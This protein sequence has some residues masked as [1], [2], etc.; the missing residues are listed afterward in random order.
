M[1][2]RHGLLLLVFVASA[3]V[4]YA[5]KGKGH[6]GGGTGGLRFRREGGTFKVLQVADM[7]YADGRSTPCEDVLPAQDRGCSDLNT[8]AFL[9]RVL[10]AEDPDL[11]VFTGTAN[12]SLLSPRS[13][14][15]LFLSPDLSV[16]RLARD[17]SARGICSSAS[18]RIG[19]GTLN[20]ID[21]SLLQSLAESIGP[22][23]R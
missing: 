6:D 9:Y 17:S 12:S 4:A 10:R 11:V 16:L 19:F 3:A 20:I 21:Q 8:T 18:S 1:A 15:D 7:H 22:G 23:R 14:L 2:A 13:P 5:G